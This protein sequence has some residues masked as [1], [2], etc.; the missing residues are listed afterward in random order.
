MARHAASA[1]AVLVLLV[2]VVA[3]MVA[4]VMMVAEEIG[5]PPRWRISSGRRTILS[6]SY[7]RCAQ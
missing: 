1:A 4:V 7:R 2:A 5:V 6:H 3:M